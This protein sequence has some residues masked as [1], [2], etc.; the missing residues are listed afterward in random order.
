MNQL[1]DLE[2]Q[3]QAIETELESAP[4]NASLW[5]EKGVGLYLCGRY[6]SSLTALNRA[7]E[8]DP[9]RPVILYNLGNTLTELDR[10]EEAT[11]IYLQV[12]DYKPDH[13]PSMNN[14]ADIQEQLGEQ[15]RAH[16]LFHYLTQL[17]PDD[18]ITHFNLGNF[19]LRQDQ[20]IEACKCYQVAIDLDPQFGDAWFTIGWVL[21]RSGAI[22]Q[23]EEYLVKGLEMSPDHEEMQSLLDTVRERLEKEPAPGHAG[24]SCNEP[25]GPEN[26]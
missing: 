4:D 19:F 3:I 15:N 22:Q 8:L 23:S 17:A 16:E 7:R 20:P 24:C 6:E 26:R 11:D 18:P 1:E 10:L 25:T 21:H 9:D 12:L 2:S 13:I 14:L 5:M